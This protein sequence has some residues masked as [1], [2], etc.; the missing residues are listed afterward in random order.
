MSQA[1]LRLRE[2][3]V[4]GSFSGLPRTQDI[5]D[6]QGLHSVV[7]KVE[8]VKKAP[9]LRNV[10]KLKSYLGVLSYYSRFLPNLT[11]QLAPLHLLLKH[12][13]SWCWKAG[14]E[15]AFIKSKELLTSPRVIVDFDPELDVI[16]ACDAS[17]YDIK[18]VLSPCMP[19]GKEKP[20]GF[21]SRTLTEA[22]KKYSQSEKE[23]LAC[24]FGIRRFHS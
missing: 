15:K 8:A 13:Q 2:K 24:V 12:H 14:Q 18:A 16:L 19:D 5:V 6:G 20:I 22:E 11:T 21:V 4:S 17:A 23:N 3:C 9:T 10:T 7:E 1:G